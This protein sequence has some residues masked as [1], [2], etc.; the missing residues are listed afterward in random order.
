MAPTVRI[1]HLFTCEADF[2]RPSG[3]HGELGSTKLVGKHVA[4]AAKTTSD[5][6]GD[7][8]HPTGRESQYCRQGTVHIVRRLRSTPQGQRAVWRVLGHGRVL[9]HGQVRV[10]LKEKV[11]S[12]IYSAS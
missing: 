9:L 7:H 11:S 2:D 6:R 4:F 8:A 5:R 1:K 12:R 3:Q 10:T